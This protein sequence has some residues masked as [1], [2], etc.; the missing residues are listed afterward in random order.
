MGGFYLTGPNYKFSYKHMSDIQ[1]KCMGYHSSISK[2]LE[3]ILL[4]SKMISKTELVKLLLNDGKNVSGKEHFG[5]EINEIYNYT[6][7]KL[8]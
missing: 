4:Q 5:L 6:Y 3:D 2:N 7:Q 1:C 8:K